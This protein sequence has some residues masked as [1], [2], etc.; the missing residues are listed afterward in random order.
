MLYRGHRRPHAGAPRCFYFR[1]LTYLKLGR[2]QDAELDFQQGAKL[3]TQNTELGNRTYNVAQGLERIQGSERWSVEQYRVGARLAAVKKSDE[4]PQ[5]P[6]RREPQIGPGFP[7]RGGRR[8]QARSDRTAQAGNRRRI[9]SAR[10]TPQAGRGRSREPAV[11]TP[12]PGTD[13]PAAEKP[14]AEKPAAPTEKP[15]ATPAGEDPFSAAPKAGAPAEKPAAT[16]AADDPFGA[17]PEPAA[18]A[19]KPEAKPAA[20]DPFGSGPGPGVKPDAPKSD[21]AK[22]DAGPAAEK[23]AG[24]LAKPAAPLAKP[25]AAAGPA[26]DSEEEPAGRIGQGP[27]RHVGQR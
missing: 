3:E 16:P 13:K 15:A 5:G 18:P 8:R 6:L 9:R 22:P 20:D 12:S 23:P 24:P 2:P 14:A 1:G 7:E 10:P 27:V 17:M 25:A 21:T 19:A 4:E 26:P 11:E